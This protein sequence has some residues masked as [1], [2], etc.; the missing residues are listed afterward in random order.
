M[1]LILATTLVTTMNTGL[2]GPWPDEQPPLDRAVIQT[3]YLIGGDHKI[4]QSP[5]LNI[6][7]YDGTQLD[8]STD[9]AWFCLPPAGA[10]QTL[11][12]AAI[13]MRK[14]SMV[15][16]LNGFHV[17]R[18]F[19]EATGGPSRSLSIYLWGHPDAETAAVQLAEAGKGA[20]GGSV[21]RVPVP[22]LELGD[23]VQQVLGGSG[24]TLEF[25]L[26]RFFARVDAHGMAAGVGDRIAE[27][28]SHAVEFRIWAS[29]LMGDRSREFVLSNGVK[30]RGLATTHGYVPLSEI[31]R[32]GAVVDSVDDPARR[33]ATIRKGATT[34]R[35]DEYLREVR[36]NG[37]PV[38][39][40][41]PIPYKGDLWVPVRSVVEALGYTIVG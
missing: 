4:Y 38:V 35:A 21:R 32:L 18:H 23:Q 25:R 22:G 31:A 28:A 19:D 6:D 8:D 5:S 11:R 29:G 41:P 37:S 39:A 24:A 20:S 15:F 3:S 36:V 1:N 13:P 26:D 14:S 33:R 40:P 9:Q 30:L 7:F 12:Q 34:V 17:W 2:Q 27:E 10:Q 16:G